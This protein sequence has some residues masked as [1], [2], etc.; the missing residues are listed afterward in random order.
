MGT[1]A[2][3][4]IDIL[5]T[6]LYVQRGYP[7]VEW[8][9]LRREAPVFW[10]ERPN[11]T[12]FWAVTKHADLVAVSGNPLEDITEMER[13]KFVMKGGTVYKNDYVKR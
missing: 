11:T 13:V 9:L 7:Q 12:P 1:L 6:D 10:Y 2:L 3:E 8:T 5:D 4:T